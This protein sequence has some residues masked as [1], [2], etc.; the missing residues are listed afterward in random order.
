MTLSYFSRSPCCEIYKKIRQKG[1][2]DYISSLIL[3]KFYIYGE[4]GTSKFVSMFYDLDLI[5]KV[6]VKKDV[7]K[8]VTT[9]QIH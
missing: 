8:T 4:I 3:F 9:G 5:F 6:T 1:Y 2:T 7:L